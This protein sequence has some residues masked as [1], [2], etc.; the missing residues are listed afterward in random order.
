M[1]AKNKQSGF[2]IV[3]LLIVIVVIGILA[4]ITIVAYNGIQERAR[5]S[6]VMSALSQASKKIKTWQVDNPDIAPATLSDV[7]LADTNTVNYQYNSSNG[8][9][10]CLTAQAGSTAYYISD[11]SSSPQVGY[12]SD[13][14]LLVWNKPQSASLPVPSATIDT[15]VFRTSTASMRL[16]PN[17]PGAVVR[18]GPYTGT[19]QT[20]TVSFWLKTDATWNGS[21]NNSKVRFGDTS[22]G[23]PLTVCAY[24]GVKTAWTYITCSHTII[25]AAPSV[26]VSVGNDGTTGNIWID[27]YRFTRSS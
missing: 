25:S 2:T 15:S 23:S 22:N 16:G 14:N 24:N 27:D 8:V 11:I 7:G 18:G 10:Y 3:E 13:Y 26:S 21:A 5:T 1:W 6:S 9:N 20:Y 4:A 17:S 12:C 19:G